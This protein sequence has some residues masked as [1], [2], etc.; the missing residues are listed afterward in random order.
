[1]KYRINVNLGFITDVDV[2]YHP[3][4]RRANCM[5]YRVNI[6]VDFINDYGGVV[7]PSG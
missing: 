1:M 7:D 5:L 6:S 2:D 3:P 4:G